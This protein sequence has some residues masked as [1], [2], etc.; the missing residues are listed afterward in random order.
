[1]NQTKSAPSLA[2]GDVLHKICL[3]VIM[4]TS[5]ENNA[6]LNLIYE[7]AWLATSGPWIWACSPGPG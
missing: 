5:Q 2:N 6:F 4:K 3:P 1:M 7:M